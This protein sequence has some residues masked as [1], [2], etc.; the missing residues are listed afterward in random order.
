MTQDDFSESYPQP[1]EGEEVAAA[2]PR[3][4]APWEGEGAA[5][6][7]VENPSD[8][9]KPN[10]LTRWY[11]TLAHIGLGESLVRISTTA[12]FLLITIA[13]VW[14]LRAFYTGPSTSGKAPGAL[15]AAP[16]A[17]AALSESGS[18]IQPLDAGIS[19]VG[20]RRFANLHT[21]IPDRPRTEVEAYTVVEGDT[22]IG[23]AEKYGLRPQTVLWGNYYTLRDDPHNLRPGQK[24]NILPVDGTYYEWQA[25][26]GLNGVAEFFGVTPEEII[27]FP[28]NKLDASTL[29][30]FSNPNIDPGTWLIVPGGE[31]PFISWSAP[32]G[33]TRTDP[34]SASVLGPGACEAIS[35][36][37]VGFGSFVWPTDHHF[38]SGFGYSPETN[39]FGIDLDG[40]TGDPIYAADA[41]VVVYSGWNDW[42]YGN[43]IIV[44]HGDN[45]QSL[46]A[47]LSAL[48]YG[49]GQSVGQGTVIGAMGS[50]GNSTGSHLHFELM[51]SRYSKVNP[52]DFL[53]PP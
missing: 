7:P 33:V 30:D 44:D 50:T 46:Y 28:A 9:R 51:H 34:A 40:E 13:I 17:A 22:V 31:R 14:V 26:D 11:D 39:H 20:L 38:L 42:G 23:V 5:A 35:G 53:P 12:I 8:D 41:G 37:A 49:C 48:N 21:V 18:V 3:R 52:F 25:G 2:Y 32:V 15:A 4:E 47:H 36:G 1:A 19:T 45:W 16:T 29:G 27:S 43:M 6:A 24:L 10:I